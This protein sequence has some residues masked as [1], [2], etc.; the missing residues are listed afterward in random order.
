VYIDCIL[1]FTCWWSVIKLDARREIVILSVINRLT[2]WP[3]YLT[4]L[5]VCRCMDCGVPFCQSDHGC[6]LGNIIP[7]WND[8]V[9]QVCS[10]YNCL[11]LQQLMMMMMMMML[12]VNRPFVSSDNLL[13]N[14]VSNTLS[15]TPRP[16]CQD[17]HQDTEQ[18]SHVLWKDKS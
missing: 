10:W 7:K 8:L 5:L 14:D 4:Q 12:L 3:S 6:P 18:L 9:F 13:R 2:Y 17:L 11:Q 16:S 15:P 1:D